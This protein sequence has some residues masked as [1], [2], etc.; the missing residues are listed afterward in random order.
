MNQKIVDNLKNL[1]EAYAEGVWSLDITT[2]YERKFHIDLP[3]TCHTVLALCRDLPDV[4]KVV[5][6]N[7]LGDWRVFPASAVIPDCYK[8][9]SQKFAKTIEEERHADCEVDIFGTAALPGFGFV[10]CIQIISASLHF[11]FCFIWG[12]FQPVITAMI[13]PFWGEEKNLSFLI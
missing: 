4:F 2:L 8:E 6:P 11:H 5:R 10:S 9:G 3:V 7:M 13:S 12:N 1:I